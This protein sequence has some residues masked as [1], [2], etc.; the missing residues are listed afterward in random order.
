[1]QGREAVVDAA[2]IRRK[3]RIDLLDD[4]SL[5]DYVL[6]HAGLAIARVDESEARETLA[7]VRGLDIEV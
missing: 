6:V 7:L 1:M 2:G 4:L 5:G 3:I